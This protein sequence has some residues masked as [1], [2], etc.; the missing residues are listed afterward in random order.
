M[1]HK[2]ESGGW[3]SSIQ[4]YINASRNFRITAQI[5]KADGIQNN[6]FGVTFGKKDNDNQNHFLI[7]GDGSFKLFSTKMVPELLSKIG[8][9][10]VI[11]KPEM[12]YIIT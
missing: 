7:S 3:S 11:L 9:N 4:K 6:G 2:R 5:K 10:R 1:E 12:E 8:Q